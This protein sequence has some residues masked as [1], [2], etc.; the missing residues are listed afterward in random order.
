MKRTQAS[1]EVSESTG[2][3]Q[4]RIKTGRQE[5]YHDKQ[6]ESD[7]ARVLLENFTIAKIDVKWKFQK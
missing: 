7:C 4:K 1:E 6:M 3:K 5:F 2:Q